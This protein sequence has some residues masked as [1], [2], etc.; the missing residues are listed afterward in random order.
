MTKVTYRESAYIMLA[1]NMHID[2]SKYI[3][4]KFDT[5]A[6]STIVSL[7]AISKNTTLT[8][9]K[10][11]SLREKLKR[12]CSDV[13]EFRS[14]SGH[15]IEGFLTYQDD[16]KLYN[17]NIPRFYYYLTLQNDIKKFLIGDDFISF[18]K[19]SHDKKSDII[20]S[21]FYYDDYIE[22]IETD[23]NT[24]GGI[25]INE[26]YTMLDGTEEADFPPQTD[27]YTYIKNLK[28]KNLI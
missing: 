21:E 2:K 24:G 6:I 3:P 14:A 11:E 20:I 28:D 16:V 7:G 13:K 1:G 17:L 23:N 18:C 10:I 22:S 4:A 12:K 25:S 8:S 9:D 26:V 19:F 5:G 15:T 27:Y